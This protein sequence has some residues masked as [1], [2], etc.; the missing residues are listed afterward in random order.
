MKKTFVNAF[1]IDKTGTVHTYLKIKVQPNGTIKLGTNNFELTTTNSLIYKG[2]KTYIYAE[3]NNMPLKPD[4]TKGLY[5]SEE[6]NSG[7]TQTVLDKLLVSLKGNTLDLKNLF[8]MIFGFGL[9]IVIGL[10]IY[11]YV[12]LKAL[13]ESLRPIITTI[14]TGG[15]M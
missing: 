1:V 5:T 15:I 12:D 8:Y 9:V 13:I 7:L 2:L 4:L 3:D 11:F 6:Y 14:T 10:L